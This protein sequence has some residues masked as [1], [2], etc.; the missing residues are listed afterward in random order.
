MSETSDGRGPRPADGGRYGAPLTMAPLR[1][2][3]ES[4]APDTLTSG[5]SLSSGAWVVPSPLPFDEPRGQLCPWTVPERAGGPLGQPLRY[6][7]QEQA[8]KR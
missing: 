5:G 7:D 4:G 1:C 3:G 8:H 2:G 6:E